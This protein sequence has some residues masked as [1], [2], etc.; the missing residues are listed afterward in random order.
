MKYFSYFYLQKFSMYSLLKHKRGLIFGALDEQS[1]AWRVAERCHEAGARFVLTN[2]PVA[3]RLGKVQALAKACG[4]ALVAADVTQLS[5]IEALIEESVDS[6]GGPLDFVLHSIGMSPN[7]RKNRSYGDLN[8]DWFSKTLDISAISL[9]KILQSLEKKNAIADWGSV[10][11]LSYVAAQRTFAGYSDMAEA[12]ALL[13]SIARSYGQR[14]GTTKKVRVNT[15]SQSPTLTTAGT[16]ISGFD[17][18]YKYA[19]D[20]SPLGNATADDCASLCMF[21]FSDMSRRIT[22]Q[23][24]MNDGGF[25]SVGLSEKITQQLQP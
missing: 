1:I 9:H 22:M 6:L 16:G 7:V 2:A 19:E 18:F 17:L 24:L 25:S 14:L 12:K 4:S 23:N 21:L 15:I 8:Y 10:V 20:M 13:E 11:A 3:L 5:D